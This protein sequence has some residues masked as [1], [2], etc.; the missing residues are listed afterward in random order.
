MTDI[1]TEMAALIEH[2]E[3]KIKQLVKFIW[4]V[5]A[6][7]E[8]LRD[9]QL[10]NTLIDMDF[11]SISSPT[12]GDVKDIKIKELETRLYKTAEMLDLSRKLINVPELIPKLDL[13][14]YNKGVDEHVCEWVDDNGDVI[15]R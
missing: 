9:Q 3:Y 14:A 4:G 1:K 10:M 11:N 7:P 2:Q 12:I 8:I 15:P 13:V 6:N 5:S